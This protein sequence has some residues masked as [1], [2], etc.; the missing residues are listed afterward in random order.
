MECEAL[1]V[2]G[3]PMEESNQ[4]TYLGDTF[5]KSGRI[6]KKEKQEDMA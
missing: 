6:R 1:K 5:D 3:S 4:E 2:H